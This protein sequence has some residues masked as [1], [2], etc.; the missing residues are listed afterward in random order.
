MSALI[1][2]KKIV[3]AGRSAIDLNI[4]KYICSAA[5][6]S[7]SE[8]QIQILNLS[9]KT[10]KILID[11]SYECL[12][13]KVGNRTLAESI[14]ITCKEIEKMEMDYKIK[15]DSVT[16]PLINKIKNKTYIDPIK[17]LIRNGYMLV[18]VLDIENLKEYQKDFLNTVESFPEY[19]RHPDPLVSRSIGENGFPILYALGGFSAFGNPSSFHNDFVRHL[20]RRCRNAIIPIFKNIIDHRLAPRHPNSTPKKTGFKLEMLIDRMM[21]RY[22]SMKPSAESWHRDV[23]PADRIL[24]DDEVYGG[25]LNLD[26][27]PQFFSCILGSHLNIKQ[28]EVLSGFDVAPL[29]YKDKLNKKKNSVK[30]PPGYMIVFPQYIMHEVLNKKADRNM[31][32]VFT[33]WRLTR[34]SNFSVI[35]LPGGMKPPIYSKSHVMFF[36][37]NTFKPIP[38]IP[39]YSITVN[40]WLN[41][42]FKESIFEKTPDGKRKIP[43]RHLKSLKSYTIGM[44]P[45]QV[46]SWLECCSPYTN[47]EIS[48]YSPLSI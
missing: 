17:N 24:D 27:E 7:L 35:S 22:T 16:L 26:K 30:I 37:E 15:K 2:N 47:E 10:K 21:Y 42:T 43:P 31:M 12:F 4:I 14:L 39:S 44:D 32:R 20:R 13:K 48:L 23:I 11:L 45:Q 8:L 29:I 40:S 38:S 28:K 1:Q 46:S 41:N 25:W 3:D 5:E 19:K 6:R 36:M 9:N 33:G 18:K 34:G